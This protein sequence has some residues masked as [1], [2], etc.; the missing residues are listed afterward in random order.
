MTLY[1]I[2]DGAGKSCRFLSCNPYNLHPWGYVMAYL[3]V[4]I[5]LCYSMDDCQAVLPGAIR[6]ESALDWLSWANSRIKTAVCFYPLTTIDAIRSEYTGTIDRYTKYL[7]ESFFNQYG[8]PTGLE[9]LKPMLK[10]ME[11]FQNARQI[12]QRLA[13]PFQLGEQR[14]SLLRRC[15]Y[16]FIDT[17]KYIDLEPELAA[18]V[19]AC[20]MEVF[21]SPTLLLQAVGEIEDEIRSSEAKLQNLLY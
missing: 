17:S 6:R 11:N 5:R 2:Y 7:N 8:P 4:A 21:S 9:E 19:T 20:S 10:R 14:T 16:R 12:N 15:K 1:T 3:V 18:I 13:E